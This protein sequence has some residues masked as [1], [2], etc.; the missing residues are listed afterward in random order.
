MQVVYR[1]C[2]RTLSLLIRDAEDKGAPIR[3]VRLFF[4][5]NPRDVRQRPFVRLE[6]KS[7][8]A[9]LNAHMRPEE[10]KPVEDMVPRWQ[11][12]FSPADVRD[13]YGFSR[14]SL[15][16]MLKDAKGS[17]QEI[18]VAVMEFMNGA[19]E[20]RRNPF[21]RIERK[22]LDAYLAAHVVFSDRR[23]RR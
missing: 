19:A 10:R 8:E 16:R 17:G 20:G 14:Q 13:I 15:W 6:R 22:S 2:R 21:I 11:Q 5:D 12:W 23:G 18:K 3:I 9:Y 4:A 1:M 7:L